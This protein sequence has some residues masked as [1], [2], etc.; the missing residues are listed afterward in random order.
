[1]SHGSIQPVVP[2]PRAALTAARFTFLGC[3]TAAV[4]TTGGLASHQPLIIGVGALG[5]VLSVVVGARRTGSALA[6]GAVSLRGAA[7]SAA[8]DR[9]SAS[10][11]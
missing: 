6:A 5:L 10:G 2:T 7:E 8:G 9:R 1:M 11:P 3:A 4:I